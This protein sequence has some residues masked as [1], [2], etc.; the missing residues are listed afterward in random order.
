MKYRGFIRRGN[1]TSLEIGEKWVR[2]R[3]PGTFF[4]KN[5]VNK[6]SFNRASIMAESLLSYPKQFKSLRGV[7]VINEGPM[8]K[9]LIDTNQPQK[10]TEKEF[11]FRV[12]EKAS[13]AKPFYRA[14][15]PFAVVVFGIYDMMQNNF[16]WG[17]WIAVKAEGLL[18]EM[19][20][21][22]IGKKIPDFLQKITDAFW[23][24]PIVGSW[25]GLGGVIWV[26]ASFAVVYQIAHMSEIADA[27]EKI[28]KMTRNGIGQME[29]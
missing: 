3:F 22:G 28:R 4:K 27:K 8:G 25:A 19:P 11:A 7:Y 10:I 13:L 1:I 21:L 2:I 26:A 23:D 15:A 24:I 6:I 9:P 14:M 17:K 5:N 18:L 20:A 12:S 29:K 16:A